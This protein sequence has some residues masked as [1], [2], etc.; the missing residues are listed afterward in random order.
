MDTYSHTIADTIGQAIATV[1][2]A[3][4]AFW[5]TDLYF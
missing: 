4:A 1:F 2:K 3:Y 5:D